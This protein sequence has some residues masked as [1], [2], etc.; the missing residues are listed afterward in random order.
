MGSGLVHCVSILVS[1]G[2]GLWVMERD[3]WIIILVMTLRNKRR[4]Y[5]HLGKSFLEKRDWLCIRGGGKFILRSG[6]TR[7]TGCV[8][9]RCGKRRAMGVGGA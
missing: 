5:T 8:C 9:G 7:N 4:V 1:N 3:G 6:G 2:E